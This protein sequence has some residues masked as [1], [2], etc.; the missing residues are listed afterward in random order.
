MTFFINLVLFLLV[1]FFYIHVTAQFKKSEDL[2]IYEM[3]YSDNAHLQEVCDVNV[4]DLLKSDQVF[5]TKNAV[6]A[7]EKHYHKY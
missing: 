7:L 5:L 1:L 6:E 4:Y 2:E 3:D